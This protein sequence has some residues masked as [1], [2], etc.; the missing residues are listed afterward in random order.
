MVG[1]IWRKC[2]GSKATFSYDQ[3]P[4]E[5][6]CSTFKQMCSCK[7]LRVEQDEKKKV[8][9]FTSQTRLFLIKVFHS[10]VS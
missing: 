6:Q 8:K 2:G 9:S 5:D 1:I 3:A 4:S 10:A 7:L